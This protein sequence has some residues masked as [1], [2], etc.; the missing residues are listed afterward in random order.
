MQ[1]EPDVFEHHNRSATSRRT[2][3]GAGVAAC[4]PMAAQAKPPRPLPHLRNLAPFPLGVEITTAQID[5]PSAV[6]LVSDNFNQITPGLA[7]KMERILK[8]DGT[9]DFDQAD[10]M[11]AFAEAH[12]LSVHGHN[13]IW[14]VYR[15]EPFTRIANEPQ[16]F[17]QAYRNYITDVARRYRGRLRGWDVVNEPV[18]EDGDGYR[19]CLWREMLGMD[20]IARALHYAREA[21]PNAVLFINEYNLE[22]RPKKLATFLRLIETLLKQG[23]P[24]TGL[25][26]QLHMRWDQPL[27][28]VENMMRELSAFGLP[29]HV[30]ELDVSTHAN[31]LNFTP[32]E[33]RLRVQAALVAGTARAYRR[34]PRAQQ[35]ALTFWDLRD[36]DSWLRLPQY[37]GDASEAPTLFD[38]QGRPKLAAKALAQALTGR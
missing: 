3:L 14:Y 28:G 30:S 31:R 23:A 22:S 6:A 33:E 5:D 34:L 12:G 37:G 1:A 38:D 18:A 27:S 29:I 19:Q 10:R 24:L 7:L 15:P 9:F 20:Y 32:L 17:A 26:T 35:Y 21:D 11:L 25:G 8:D 4:L 36:K 2:I 16:R 13:L